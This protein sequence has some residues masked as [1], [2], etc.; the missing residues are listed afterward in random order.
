L[1]NIYIYIQ[2]RKRIINAEHCIVNN[3]SDGGKMK[4]YET[5]INGNERWSINAMKLIPFFLLKCSYNLG[6]ENIIA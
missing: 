6:V 4:V 1:Y 2:T 3:L 5:N